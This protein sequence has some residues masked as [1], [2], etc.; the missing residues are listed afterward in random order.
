M[1]SP[2]TLIFHNKSV[3]NEVSDVNIIVKNEDTAITLGEVYDR[4]VL[5]QDFDVIAYVVEVKP[6][7]SYQKNDKTVVVRDIVVA[8]PIAKLTMNARL[9]RWGQEISTDMVGKVVIFSRFSMNEY[10]GSLSLS[11]NMRSSLIFTHE[12]PMKTY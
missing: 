3:F 8:D 4:K 11:S 12:H 1:L 5:H 2:Y 7:T 9:W 10:K 6:E